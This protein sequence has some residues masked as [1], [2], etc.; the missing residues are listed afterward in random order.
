MVSGMVMMT[1]LPR[2]AA[3]A[4]RPMPVLPDVG[5]MITVSAFSLP[6]ASASSSMA[7]AMRSFTEPAGLNSSTLP[8]MVASRLWFFS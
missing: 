4:H 7:F 8:T 3:M 6:C 5:S 2:A 1:R